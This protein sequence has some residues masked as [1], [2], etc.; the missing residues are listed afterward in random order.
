MK[1][2]LLA[3]AAALTLVTIPMTSLP[4]AAAP[5]EGKAPATTQPTSDSTKATL[6]V[7]PSVITVAEA[8]KG[9]K[10]IARATGLT[11]NGEYLF[12]P[13][14]TPELEPLPAKADAEG[15]VTINGEIYKPNDTEEAVGTYTASLKDAGTR[16]LVASATWRIV[17]DKETPPT[18]SPST[19]TTSPSTS[20]TPAE[21]PT[22]TAAPSPTQTAAKP[23]LTARP[24]RVSAAD[25]VNAKKGVSLTAAHCTP[26]ETV[27]F[28]VAPKDSDV[29]PLTRKATANASGTAAWNVY[30]T[31]PSSPAAYIGDYVVSAHCGGKKLSAAF[32]VGNAPRPGDDGND[33]DHNDNGGDDNNGGDD[34]NGSLPRTGMELGGLGAGAALLLMGG[35]TVLF[36]RRSRR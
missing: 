15:R 16:S 3:A 22:R 10:I 29:T 4:A 13:R 27:N 25:F 6:T 12:D 36:T 21:T 7:T 26:G 24:A 5:S 11:P 34:G 2:T 32:S 33:G 9:T 19:S 28:S 23:A 18:T 30:G 14:D 17:R 20:T 1:K 8:K 31:N 35:A